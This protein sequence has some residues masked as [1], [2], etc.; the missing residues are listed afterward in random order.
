MKRRRIKWGLAL[1]TAGSIVTVQKVCQPAVTP[2]KAALN[3]SLRQDSTAQVQARLDSLREDLLQKARKGATVEKGRAT[4]YSSRLRK[5]QTASGELHHADSLVC[6]HMKHPFGTLLRVYNP[7]NGKEVVVKVTDR[8]PFR[9]GFIVDLSYRAA[10]E[11][12][13]IR[14]GHMPVE[15]TV[16][17]FTP[18][19]VRKP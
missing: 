10:K 1:L 17:G 8:G 5:A 12:G 2:G 11:I 18:P 7:A 14:A 6:A 16:V 19:V 13:I 9:K 4:F 3:D 15:V